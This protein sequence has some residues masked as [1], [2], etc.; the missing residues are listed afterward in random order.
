MLSAANS[1]SSSILRYARDD[2]PAPIF[3]VTIVTA[4]SDFSMTVVT[5]MTVVTLELHIYTSP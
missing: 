2:K 4:L 3:I 5:V 1:F